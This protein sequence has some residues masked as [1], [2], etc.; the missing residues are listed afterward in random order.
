MYCEFCYEE[1]L[2]TYC[3]SDDIRPFDIYCSVNCMENLTGEILNGE[4][5]SHFDSSD[6]Y[7]NEY[8]NELKL[9]LENKTIKYKEHE[10]Y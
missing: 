4:W 5:D 8:K 9:K 7:K 6:E 1:N 3:T 2:K 10:I